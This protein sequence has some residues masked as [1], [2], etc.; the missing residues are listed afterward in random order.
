M[1]I[2]T[3]VPFSSIAAERILVAHLAPARE[4]LFVSNAD[5][6]GE[7]TIA[8]S[9]SLDYNPSWSGKGGWIVFTSERAG[10]ADLF[11]VHPDGMGLERLTDDP[12]FDDQAAFSPDERQI[13]FV[14]TRAGGRANLWVLDSASRQ[15]RQLTSGDGGDFRPAWSPDGEWIAFSSDRGSDLPPAPQRW[16]RL[17]LADIYVIHPDGTGLRRLTPGG[18][19]CGSPKWTADS[20]NVIGYCMTAQNSW[21]Y[22]FPTHDVDLDGNTTLTEIRIADGTETPLGVVPGIKLVPTVLA[23]GATGY[24]R[25][26]K[27]AA[28]VFYT[29]GKTGPS[30]KDMRT[31]S[32]SPDGTRLVYGRVKQV[33]FT[34]LV[35]LFSHANGYTLYAAR[36]EGMM[37]SYTADGAHYAGL[38]Q[39]ANDTAILSVGEFG[40]PPKPILQRK[41]LMLAPQWSPDGLQIAF[42]IG[43]FTAFLD[44]DAGVKTPVT[45]V[46]GGAQVGLI[47]ADGSGF[48]LVTSGP[49]N[50]AFPS[51]SPD[52]TRIVYRTAGPQGNGLRIMNLATK[53]IT[54]LTDEYD[55][56]P[57]WSPRG[58]LIAFV[59][60]IG[61]NFL[62]FTIH[63][64]GSG[65]K[66]LTDCN[67][68][69]AHL[70]WS[71][72]G[73]HI[74]FASSRMGFKDEAPLVGNPQPY[75]EIYVMDKDGSHVT[76]L[77]DDQWEDGAPS[78]MPHL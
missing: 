43:P 60:K 53:A 61:N 34:G 35:P 8:E 68:N 5:G 50:N 66:Q 59:R 44:F 4:T 42:G 14:S 62:V 25:L 58:D 23:S 56:F 29:N 47:N 55:N 48:H 10:S 28:G 63:P 17:Q 31:P 15:A 2:L 26:D 30:G 33:K 52:G 7:H 37:P 69:D 70:N 19:F 45:R 12:A 27:T 78:W 24:L 71:P 41:E 75:G 73:E 9:D 49:N 74:V 11:R 21:D 22:R 76:Q 65:I 39:G 54:P 57:V 51:Y 77:T 18:G 6:S 72:D 13:V 1:G 3:L 38:I 20:K 32:W 40:K 46:N 64:D 16:E 36:M 67:C